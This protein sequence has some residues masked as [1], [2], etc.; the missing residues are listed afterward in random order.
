MSLD[1]DALLVINHV[2]FSVL[3]DLGALR[4]SLSN[5]LDVSR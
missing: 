1:N 4:V 2:L 3:C 5:I